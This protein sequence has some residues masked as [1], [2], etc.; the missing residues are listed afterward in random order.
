MTV[1]VL[2]LPLLVPANAQTSVAR[3]SGDDSA[4][5][6]HAAGQ[7]RIVIGFVGGFVR[8][9]EKHHPEVLMAARLRRLEG[10]NI[11][12]EVFDNL[13]RKKAFRKILRALDA[14][15]DGVVSAE[16]KEQARIIIYGHSWGA[17]ETVTLAR[18]LE[19]QNIPVLLTIQM[20]SIS[21]LWEE[22]SV[23]PANVES[24]I[25]FYQTWGP[26]QGRRK[27]RAAD[28]TRTKI[29][30]NLKMTYKEHPVNCDQDPWFARLFA[31]THMEIEND[32]RIWDQIFSLINADMPRAE[33][34]T[35]AVVVSR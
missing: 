21:K 15:H 22:D 24:A 8:H 27:I 34:P 11:D 3:F 32:P 25:N 10:A 1:F 23:I 7:K 26:I 33:P 29:L 35:G 20:D 4:S 5:V 9:D 16:E 18:E 6:A 28:P 31:K 14:D 17:S 12:A 13:H 30:G 19:R 2:L